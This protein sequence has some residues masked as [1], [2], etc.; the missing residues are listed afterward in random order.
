VAGFPRKI[1]QEAFGIKVP[2]REFT[3]LKIHSRFPGPSKPVQPTKIFL[4]RIKDEVIV[5]LLAC[6]ESSDNLQQTAFG[7][8]IVE[9][10]GGHDFCDN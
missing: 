4:N 6:L 3:N 1:L 9:I 10:L 7:T 5:A 8:K 2:K